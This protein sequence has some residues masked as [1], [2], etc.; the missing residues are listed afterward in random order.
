MPVLART[1]EEVMAARVN[2]PT[3]SNTL[4]VLEQLPGSGIKRLLAIGWAVRSRR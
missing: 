2:K 4:S 3:L 1:P